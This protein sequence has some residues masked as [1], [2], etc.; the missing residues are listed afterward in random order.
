MT[1]ARRNQAQTHIHPVHIIYYEN[2]ILEPNITKSQSVQLKYIKSD[3]APSQVVRDLWSNL[4][5]S[6]MMYDC[7]GD[8]S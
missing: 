3:S 7:W 6:G 4:E 5:Q 1:E 2:H 8:G